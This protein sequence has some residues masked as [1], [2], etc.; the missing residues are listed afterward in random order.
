MSNTWR[1][2]FAGFVVTLFI[3]TAFSEEAFAQV[4]N[5]RALDHAVSNPAFPGPGLDT[6]I[7]VS[8]GQL[9][10][11]AAG[12]SDTWT[13]DSSSPIFSSTANGLVGVVVPLPLG[14]F[15]FP[16]GALIGSLDMGKTFFAIGTHMEM[17]VLR[18]GTL[19]LYC[20]DSGFFNND[21][22]IKVDVN[23]YT[24]QKPPPAP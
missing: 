23:V 12:R 19:R 20:W 15:T 1:T 7:K 2:N 5:V 22:S 14:E 21:G 18:P 3:C 8:W 16:H 4:F 13:I 24:R 6:N 10:I 9:L 11:I 17:T